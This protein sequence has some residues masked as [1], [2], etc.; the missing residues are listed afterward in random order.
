MKQR[1]L[2][3]KVS[4][5]VQTIS[6]YEREKLPTLENVALIADTLHVSVDWL[7]GGEQPK[8]KPTTY[9]D[10]FELIEALEDALFT[11]VQPHIETIEDHY[12][13]PN[14]DRCVY[15][16]ELDCG[17][18]LGD[19]FIARKEIFNLTTPPEIRRRILDTWKNGMI[20][21]LKQIPLP[22]LPY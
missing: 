8:G 17:K 3:D 20:E 10:L 7:L 2:A 16:L 4:V 22:Q 6:A 12:D 21:N 5:S 14:G 9:A 15:T 13:S 18:E 11:A 1:E 19:A